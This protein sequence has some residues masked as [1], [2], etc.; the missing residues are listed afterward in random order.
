MAEYNRLMM[1]EDESALVAA[2]SLK[3]YCENRECC[4]C[5]FYKGKCCLNKEPWKTMTK[6]FIQ[7]FN[8]LYNS[9][10]DA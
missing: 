6:P 3:Q 10:F 5:I 2:I 7:N 9:N 1:H 8:K 4:D